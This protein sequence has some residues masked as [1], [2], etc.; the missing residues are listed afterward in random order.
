MIIGA[1]A[2]GGTTSLVTA[3][4]HHIVSTQPMPA[5]GVVGQTHLKDSAILGA[6]TTDRTVAFDLWAPSSSNCTGKPFFSDP[7]ESVSAAQGNGSVPVISTESP[8]PT[9]VGTY[10]WTAR[11]LNGSSVEFATACGAEPV[12]ISKAQPSIVTTPS[13]G[14]AL[15]TA[16]S[17]SATVSGGDN[18]TGTVT[19]RLFKFDADCSPID[20]VFTSDAMPLVDGKA[21]SGTFKPTAIGTYA[22]TARYN[23]DA[24]NLGV[25][26]KCKDETV[27]IG[28][29]TP[30]IDTT[31]SA[32]GLIGTAI[33]DTA[34]VSGLV[35]PTG[36][37]TVT[38]TLFGP[39][40]TSCSG[41]PLWTSVAIPL[42]DG[43]AKSGQF[44]KTDTAGTYS[45]IASFSGDHNNGSVKS[46][47]GAETA[48]I[49]S[50]PASP[51]PSPTSNV[52]SVTTPETG[53]DAVTGISLGGFLILGG[54]A[55]LLTGLLFR[56]RRSENDE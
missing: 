6:T 48:V 30:A 1:L 9:Q 24:H 43:I 15:G 31:P 23:G 25:T 35:N 14:G 7:G 46:A 21:T 13:D 28:K 39:A 45:W 44:T 8:V 47:C 38:F 17:D 10:Q 50:P 53:A 42:T 3:F 33:S 5:S 18:P 12:V 36:S 51:S 54:P 41:E 2:L 19:F 20:L 16:V 49:M 11:I 26:S 56:G 32:G 4:A 52:Q 27:T 22:W 55:V 40:D 34:K 37:G 29:A